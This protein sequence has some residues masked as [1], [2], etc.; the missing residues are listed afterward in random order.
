M[1]HKIKNYQGF[2]NEN[3]IN[4]FLDPVTLVFAL[5]GIGIAFGSEIAEFYRNRKIAKS[6]LKDLYLLKSKAEAKVKKYQAREN[7]HAEAEA[8][9]QLD[10]IQAQIDSK[11]REFQEADDKI[12]EFEKDK[13][14]QKELKSELEDMDSRSLKQVI[15]TAKQ[16]SRSVK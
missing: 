1:K 13:K 6:S 9:E 8:Q 14:A 5:A 2:V 12:K 15:R 10:L 3:M 16:D 7:K 4:E 11:L